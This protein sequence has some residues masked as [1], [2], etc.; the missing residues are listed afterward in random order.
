VLAGVFKDHPRVRV[1][2]R[3]EL[4]AALVGRADLILLDVP[5]SNTGVLPRR[6]EARYRLTD[7]TL[8][9]MADVQRQ[10]G[11]DAIP[12]LAARG[13][14]LYSTCSLEPEENDQMAAWFTRWHNLRAQA[15]QAIEPTGLPG[16]PA[17]GYRDGSFAVLLGR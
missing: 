14:I 8:E 3:P 6:P 10:I 7:R 17:A 2:P 16:G 13:R 11:A 15:R 12:L 1:M 9:R 4:A 5:C